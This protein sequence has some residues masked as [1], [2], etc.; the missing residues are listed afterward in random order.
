MRLLTLR[1]YRLK[2]LGDTSSFIIVSLEVA[3]DQLSKSL[4]SSCTFLPLHDIRFHASIGVKY[5]QSVVLG[6]AS[7]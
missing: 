3:N 2:E 1:Y 7:S 4:P 6:S 5:V